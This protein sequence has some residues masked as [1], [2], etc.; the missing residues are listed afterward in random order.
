MVNFSHRQMKEEERRCITAVDAFNVV[1]K[2]IQ[3]LTTKLN[4]ADKDKKSAEA[5]LQV[6]ERQ[7]ESQSKKLITGLKKKLEEAEKAKDQ[8]EQDGYNVGVTETEEA[9]RVE[10]SGAATVSKKADEDKGGLA[11]IPPSS[12][13]PPK[14][15][16]QAKATKKEKGTSKGVVPNTTKPSPAPKDPSKGKETP[17]H[18]E[19]VLTSL[20]A[21]AKEDPKGKG[22]ASTVAE[23]ADST[24][25]TGKEN[26]P[27]KIK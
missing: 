5:T 23:T 20:L 2:K 19:I 3:K 4:E 27:P 8:A 12:T 7:V 11:K 1:E 18:L 10:V 21:P 25:A 14:E 26:P 24:K 9:L 17:Q 22:L 6:A 16:E 15:A 13:S